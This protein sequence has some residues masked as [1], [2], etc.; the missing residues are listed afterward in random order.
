SLSSLLASIPAAVAS[1]TSA[2]SGALFL[3]EGDRLYQ[4]G[5]QGF[6]HIEFPHLR[7]LA[8]TLPSSRTE[9]DEM[10]VPVRSGTRPKG[11]FLLQGVV[12]STATADAIGGHIA[13]SIDRAQALETLAH[14]EATRESERLRTL[15]ID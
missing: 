5:G 4:A 6:S 9:G 11:V 8:E 3:L 15:M 2:R 13:A 10:Q 14:G 1:V 7:R 12:I